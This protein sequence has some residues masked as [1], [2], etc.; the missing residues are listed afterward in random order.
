MPYATRFILSKGHAALG[1]YAALYLTGV[2]SQTDLESYGGENSIVGIHPQ[3]GLN[4]VDFTTGSLGQGLTFAA[5]CALADKI[6]DVQRETF[7][8]CSDAEC[9]EGSTWEMIM[10]AAQNKLSKL[11]LIVDYN[12]QQAMGATDDIISLT[13]LGLRFSSFGWEVSEVDG[14]DTEEIADVLLKPKQNLPRVVIA[15]TL[16][17]KGVDFMEGQLRWHYLSLSK[18]EYKKAL[19]CIGRDK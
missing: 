15:N 4:G 16:F 17:G 1:L 5:G 11:T 18:E 10:F 2:I 9:D 13:N 19:N 12:R 7:V 3:H 6:M 8:L 14:H